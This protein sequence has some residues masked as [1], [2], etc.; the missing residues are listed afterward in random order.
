MTEEQ[1]NAL[2]MVLEY[3][4][5]EQDDYEVYVEMG[6]DPTKHIYH[7]IQILKQINRS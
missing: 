2:D 7:A 4:A 6:G 1:N 5:E 3:L